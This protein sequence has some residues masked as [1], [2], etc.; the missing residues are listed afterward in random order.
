MRFVA[1]LV[2]SVLVPT[3]T[4]SAAQATEESPYRVS[5]DLRDAILELGNDDAFEREPA[6]SLLEGLGDDAV[7]ALRSALAREDESVR[8][9]VVEVL[10]SIDGPEPTRVLLEC[11]RTDPSVDVRGAALS[12]LILREDDE[13]SAEISRALRSEDPRLY[14]AALGGCGRFCT[15]PDE[16]DRIV[17]LAFREP[18][19]KFLA[20]RSALARIATMPGHRDAVVAAVERRAPGAL[21]A[22][23]PE[24][25]LRAALLLADLDD[26]RGIAGLTVALDED[27][28]LLLRIQ[29]IV[30]IG[31]TGD[32]GVV[33]EIGKSIEALPAQARPAACKALGTLASRG[34]D[35]AAAEADLREC[36][37]AG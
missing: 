18:T 16:L 23:D 22:A 19:V 6:E 20:P 14:R 21:K 11:A 37:R 25:R 8:M 13:A 29:A 9:G 33:P 12:G 5:V 15:S 28:P 34:V 3:L 4:G 7:P 32:A 31:A 27:V 35:G 36:P 1:A 26:P 17:A 10:T 24:G 30:L 2:V